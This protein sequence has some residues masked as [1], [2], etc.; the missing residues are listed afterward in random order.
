[1]S[2]F[3]MI[4]VLYS[5]TV[6]LLRFTSPPPSLTKHQHEAHIAEL[7]DEL[8]LACSNNDV[9]EVKRLIEQGA[10]I[11][12]LDQVNNDL[13]CIM[14]INLHDIYSSV[15]HFYATCFCS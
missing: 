2:H 8:R 4:F 13:I 3:E 15:V 11:Y 14:I 10:S 12:C 1:M 6:L 5:D 7:E 9:E